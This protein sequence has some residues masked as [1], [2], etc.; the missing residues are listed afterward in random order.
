[1]RQLRQS[2]RTIIIVGK[3]HGDVDVSRLPASVRK[4]C[5]ILGL[6]TDQLVPATVVNAWGQQ[7]R[8]INLDATVQGIEPDLESIRF[9]D[10]AKNTLLEWINE[11]CFEEEE[12]PE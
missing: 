9:F 3:K 12:S 5:I 6:T 1:M 2:V 8:L 10:E 4:A 11:P 7:T